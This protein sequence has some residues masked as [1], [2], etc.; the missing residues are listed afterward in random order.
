MIYYTENTAFILYKSRDKNTATSN[1]LK[2]NKGKTIIKLHFF[3]TVTVVYVVE[4][5]YLIIS[6]R[7]YEYTL[8]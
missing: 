7:L 8:T 6:T 4:Y 1:A 2:Q 3:L 5:I